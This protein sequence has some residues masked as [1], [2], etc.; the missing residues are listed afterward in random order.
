[1]KKSLCIPG[2]YILESLEEE[3]IDEKV[4]AYQ[5]ALDKLFPVLPILRPFISDYRRKLQHQSSILFDTA[6]KIYFNPQNKQKILRRNFPKYYK[7]TPLY[8]ILLLRFQT[9]FAP[10]YIQRILKQFKYVNRRYFR[11]RIKFL[12]IL[13]KKLESI[14]IHIHSREELLRRIFTDK[15]F[16]IEYIYSYIEIERKKY[17]IIKKGG[18][19]KRISLIDYLTSFRLTSVPFYKYVSNIW[20][21]I[22]EVLPLFLKSKVTDLYHIRT[23]VDGPLDIVKTGKYRYKLVKEFPCPPKYLME[24]F[25]DPEILMK[26]YPSTNIKIEELGPNRLR[27]TFTEKI[28]L[29]KIV[30]KYDFVWRYKGNIEEWWIENSN[31]IKSMTGF[32]VYEKTPKGNC[33][34]ADILT[35]FTLNNQL[36]SFEDLII[37]ALERMARKNIEQLMEKIYQF[38]IAQD[39][40]MIRTH[41][42]ECKEST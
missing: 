2:D 14:Q 33:R 29:L 16:L 39:T 1:M 13:F 18:D 19:W 31:Y 9:L 40:S 32:A 6:K 28:P 38:L 17:R 12:L 3:I 7:H 26:N 30:L 24:I 22:D 42:D 10:Q 25:H 41:Q 27:Y 36:K 35:D 4:R 8:S 23:L 11:R 37:P 20:K 34:Y 15:K 21:S 5:I